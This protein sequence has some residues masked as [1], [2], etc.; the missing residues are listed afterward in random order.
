[1]KWLVLWSLSV[2]ACGGVE[3]AEDPGM[4]NYRLEFK[5]PRGV[6]F[7]K[8]KI[9]RVGDGAQPV[10]MPGCTAVD[11]IPGWGTLTS[12]TCSV[13]LPTAVPGEFNVA[14]TTGMTEDNPYVSEMGSYFTQRHPALG[15]LDVYRNGALSK[16]VYVSSAPTS[17]EGM[18]PPTYYHPNVWDTGSMCPSRFPAKN[19][20]GICSFWSPEMACGTIE[21]ANMKNFTLDVGGLPVVTLPE[22]Q[23]DVYTKPGESLLGV[24]DFGAAKGQYC[25]SVTVDDFNL[26]FEYPYDTT[27]PGR[28]NLDLE[29]RIG[30]RDYSAPLTAN[31]GSC[32]DTGCVKHFVAFGQSNLDP[33]REKFPVAVV[34]KNCRGVAMGIEI[35]TIFTGNVHYRVGVEESY[36]AQLPELRSTAVIR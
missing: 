2:G 20:R 33:S 25:S 31:G 13:W 28:A 21:I 10:E 9:V 18:K 7:H 27:V 4:Y 17:M 8:I 1:M 34:C 14:L 30:E 29:L 12:H 11:P 15:T 24:F 36:R 6:G 22:V 3:P 19:D 26:R 16:L 5:L 23:T 35:T 32:P